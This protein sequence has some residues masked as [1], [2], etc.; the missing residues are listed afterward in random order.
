MDGLP[1]L[2]GVPTVEW[3]RF[4]PWF[5]GQWSP[6]EHVSLIGPTG[7]GKTTLALELLGRRDF[8]TVLGTKPAD[9]TLDRLVAEQ[10]YQLLRDWPHRGP[11]LDTWSMSDGTRRKRAHVVLWPDWKHGPAATKAKQRAVFDQALG[12][13]FAAG[14]WCVFADEVFYLTK[15]LGLEQHLTTIWTQGRSLGLTL[16]GG[17][18]RPA[19]VP[20]YM[21]DQ[22]T[23]LFLWGDNDERN[24]QRVG[25]LGGLS[26]RRVR[27]IVAALP[28]HAVLYVNTRT[29]QLA[30]TRVAL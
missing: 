20:L 13:M 11:K 5:R 7:S 8:V 27:A 25:G 14:R 9:D 10:G 3:A 4:R 24:L 29:R 16:V 1:E 2:E 30:V 19:Y 17:T 28:H 21:Y 22:A 26:S 18:Q 23:H 6:G 12:E 15:E